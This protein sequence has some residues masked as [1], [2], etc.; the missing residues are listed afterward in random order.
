MKLQ[1]QLSH[2][3]PHPN[4][5]SIAGFTLVELSI[6]LVILGLLV[7]GVLTGQSLIRAAEL[8]TVTTEHDKFVTAMY[9]FKDKY[10]AVPGDM[11]NAVRYWG[12]ATG[13]RADGIDTTCAAYVSAGV[14]PVSGTATC[15]G[16]GNG[17]ID[18]VTMHEHWVAWKHLSNAGL[19][20]GNYIGI[21]SDVDDSLKPGVIV[22][23][24]KAPNAE[25]SFTGLG[26]VQGDSYFFDGDYTNSLSIGSDVD[27]YDGSPGWGGFLKP[28]EAFNIDQKMDDG[29]PNAGAVVTNTS[30]VYVDCITSDETTHDLAKKILGCHLYFLH[31]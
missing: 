21:Q 25:W 12:A 7:G 17:A 13:G 1:T 6:V 16:N 14:S 29:K 19:I 30:N 8:R 26:M 24:S 23:K 22:P 3:T 20:E 27:T 9:S 11:P 28:E 2:T 5:K 15:N 31:R 4:H 10:M 18:Y